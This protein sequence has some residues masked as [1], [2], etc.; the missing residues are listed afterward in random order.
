MCW[1]LEGDQ[2]KHST[3][4][5]TCTQINCTCILKNRLHHYS[6]VCVFLCIN[7][8]IC[9]VLHTWAWHGCVCVYVNSEP[10][11]CHG[12]IITQCPSP[13][14]PVVTW[15]PNE[16][17]F[18]FFCFNLR[19]TSSFREGGAKRYLPPTSPPCYILQCPVAHPNTAPWR[20]ICVTLSSSSSLSPLLFIF[21]VFPF[22]VALPLSKYGL[23]LPV[24]FAGVLFQT[25]LA[26]SFSSSFLHFLFVCLS[27]SYL[28]IS[29]SLLTWRFFLH[30][31]SMTYPFCLF[32]SSRLL[33]GLG[34]REVRVWME[35]TVSSLQPMT[36][37]FLFRLERQMNSMC[38]RA[39][40]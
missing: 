21:F 15:M 38:V 18:F 2:Y 27:I 28:T 33:S 22:C 16:Q 39:S 14:Q 32:L 17:I 30:S 26:S 24:S 11:T 8:C 25:V 12:D 35:F 37:H 29:F 13:L 40:M 34:H 19:L 20:L 3:T 10:A 23:S 4:S 1:E 7:F 36:D 5:H 6:L 31:F 9:I